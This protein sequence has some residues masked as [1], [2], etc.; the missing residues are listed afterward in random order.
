MGNFFTD[1]ANK[2]LVN[3]G[4]FAINYEGNKIVGYV[5][6]PRYC[7][8]GN[9]IIDCHGGFLGPVPGELSH[10]Y[11]FARAGY[12]VYCLAYDQ[13]PNMSIASDT[14]EVY[15]LAQSIRKYLKPK[16]LF[17]TGV[18]RGGFVAY[19]TL[20]TYGAIFNGA[21]IFAGPCDIPKWFDETSIPDSFM[22]PAR[23]YFLEWNS[24]IS[25]PNDFITLGLKMLLLHGDKDDIVG[26]NQS[27]EMFKT[28]SRPTICQLEVIENMGHT[29]AN[30]AS[31]TSIAI[32]FFKEIS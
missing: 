6:T 4:V 29:I 8:N 7:N 3:K 14:K 31:S 25:R 19:Q 17:L 1:L 5:Y 27:M 30:Y 26:V 12:I 16:K 23:P 18:S 9:A 32:K 11:D 13:Q 10:A 24:P 22:D 28:I 20:L 15:D 2:L 21:S